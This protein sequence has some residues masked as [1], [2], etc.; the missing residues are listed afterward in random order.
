[1]SQ[2]HQEAGDR[3]PRAHATDT[4]TKESWNSDTML[5]SFQIY[6]A[7]TSKSSHSTA[8]TSALVLVTGRPGQSLGTLGAVCPTAAEDSPSQ[9]A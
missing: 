5:S 4:H 6:R 9:S 7:K 8:Q 1:M 2:E 3:C